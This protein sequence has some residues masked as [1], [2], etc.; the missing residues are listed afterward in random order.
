MMGLA[1]W[2][3][4]RPLAALLGPAARGCRRRCG[5]FCVMLVPAESAATRSCCPPA[6]LAP[7]SASQAGRRSTSSR[8]RAS[9]W[10]SADEPTRQSGRTLLLV[11]TFGLVVVAGFESSTWVGGVT[12]AVA[13]LAVGAV[14]LVR[15]RAGRTSAVRCGR[16]DR[17]RACGLPGGAVPLRSGST[18]TAMRGSGSPIALRPTDVLGEF[19]PDALRRVLDLPAFWLVFLLVEFPAVYPIGAFMLCKLAGIA[20]TWSRSEGRS[21]VALAALCAASLTVSWLLVSTDRLQRSRMARGLPGLMVLTVF[22]GG[23]LVRAGS[24]TGAV[25]PGG[26]R[27]RAARLGAAEGIRYLRENVAGKPAT[28]Q[29]GRSP[30]APALWDAVRRH[31]G[32]RRAGRQQSACFSAAST[33]GPAISPGRCWRTAVHALP[34]ISCCWP[35]RRCRDARREAI[36][37]QFIRVFAGDGSRRRYSRA[38][39]ALRLRARRGDRAGQAP[40]RAIRSRR[41][42]STSLVEEK[43]A[44]GA[45][46]VKPAAEAGPGR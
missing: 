1:A 19:L 37:W 43:P 36:D 38:C 14:L 31:L 13:A 20:R 3:A 23:G 12:F 4:G 39:H 22:V 7:G 10:R 45:S 9:C 27:S 40:G 30:E 18:A 25:D 17:G 16:R 24:P 44:S 15:G 26:G 42:R 11:A 32:P 8:R 21:T 34:A 2:I 33:P 6:A 41:A 46:T 28:S 35:S 5:R 29:G